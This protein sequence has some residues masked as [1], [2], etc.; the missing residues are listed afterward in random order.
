MDDI[1]TING[2]SIVHQ[3]RQGRQRIVDDVSFSIGAG[4]AYGLVGESGCGKSTIA[5]ALMRY[6]PQGMAITQGRIQIEGRDTASLDA[7]ALRRLRGGHLAMV[8]QDPMASLN[9]V[10]TIGRQLMEVPLLHGE[11]STARARARAIQMLE[12]VRLPDAKAM[13]ER[14]PHQLSGGQQQRVVIAMALMAE[15]KLLIMDE[16]T[17]GLDV[18]I[19]AAILDLVHELRRTFGTAILFISHNLG[20]VARLCDRIGVLYAGR[21]VET[22][23]IKPVFR[24]P[25][26]PYTRGLLA[27]LP[28]LR[29]GRR[30]ERLTP[31]EGALMPEDRERTGCSFAPRCAFAVGEICAA[32]AVPMLPLIDDGHEARC[33][34]L[35][36]VAAS[37][38][39]PGRSADVVVREYGGP[40]LRLAHL[41]KTYEIGGIF[42]GNKTRVRALAD[43]SVVAAKGQT[44]AIVGESGSGKSTLA[45][46]VSGLQPATSGSVQLGAVELAKI[47]VDDRSRDLRRRIQMVFQNPDSTLNPSH[48]VGYAL[49]RPLRLLRG[50]SKAAARQEVGAL[51]ERVR[52]PADVIDRKPQQLS[53]GQKQRIAL[54]RAIAGNPD[55]VIA[56]EPVSAL[57]VSVQAAIV[58][59][60]ADLQSTTGITLILISH[61]LALVR[62]MADWIAVMYLGRI[63]EQGPADRVLAAPFHPYT[64]ALLAAAPEPD[65]EAGPPDVILAGAMPSPSEE[66]QGCPFA[67]RCVHKLDGICELTVPPLRAFGDG[68]VI[69]CHLELGPN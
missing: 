16:P 34:R 66:L 13:L 44:L 9:P 25:A 40:A 10:M 68:H 22:G 42:S 41:T 31:I 58:N 63:V 49:A 28:R 39:R 50:L 6:L 11:R 62:H 2:L 67:S 55:L 38:A 14:Y 53:G 17:T 54:A 43:A 56:D 20:T 33:L 4:E 18:T 59:L 3:G 15:P 19:E 24:V 47:R 61:D 23:G 45:R 5:L 57:D 7:G 21:L 1:V 36:A 60:L 69:A 64:A 32:G 12:E 52:M 46:I 35:G 27:A 8:Y 30:A 51:L 37:E 29:D 26:H 48:S 65:P